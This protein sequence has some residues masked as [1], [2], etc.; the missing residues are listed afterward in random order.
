[1][2]QPSA[3]QKR[4]P[5]TRLH[6]VIVLAIIML[7]ATLASLFSN[8]A[9]ATRKTDQAQLIQLNKQMLSQVHASFTSQE[10]K[11]EVF[12]QSLPS[13]ETGLQEQ[14]PVQALKQTIIK[15]KSGHSL[16]AIFKKHKLSHQD[17]YRI[18][19]KGKMAKALRNIQPGRIIEIESNEQ[20][21]L[22]SLSYQVNR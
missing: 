20:G 9:A 2:G 8:D 21:Q 13:P 17:L 5:F 12:I 10:T 15:V 6:A 16:S 3:P 19:Q 7:I 4:P 22:Y 14:E 1:M 11:S 18:M